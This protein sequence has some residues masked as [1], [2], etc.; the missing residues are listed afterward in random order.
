M[1]YHQ[2]LKKLHAAYPTPAGVKH[3]ITLNKDDQLEITIWRADK[4]CW[5]V[6]ILDPEDEV[7][8]HGRLL[9]EMRAYL[10]I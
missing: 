10:K 6:I 3:D 9:Y 4:D 2:L 7:K 1:D 8:S 5:H